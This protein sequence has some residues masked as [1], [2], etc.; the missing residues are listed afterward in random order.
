MTPLLEEAMSYEFEE[1][2]NYNKLKFLMKK[3][4]MEK[5][6][7]FNVIDEPNMITEAD[8]EEGAKN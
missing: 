1:Q 5:E 7:F 3:V 2:P 4:L 6:R 8:V